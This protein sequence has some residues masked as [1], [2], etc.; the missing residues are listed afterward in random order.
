MNAMP[1]NAGAPAAAAPPQRPAA[2]PAGP[3][4]AR[5]PLADLLKTRLRALTPEEKQVLR[6][7]ITPEVAQVIAKVLPEIASLLGAGGGQ[8]PAGP[9]AGP[10]A[11]PRTML[12]N[13]GV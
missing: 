7:G 1:M 13:V 9:P 6:S 12:G 11:G 2:P 4:G 3:G 10:S 8:P 5:N